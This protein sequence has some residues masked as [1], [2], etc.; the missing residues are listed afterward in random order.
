MVTSDGRQEQRSRDDGG[1]DLP[2]VRDEAESTRPAMTGI[3][4]EYPTGELLTERDKADVAWIEEA[5]AGS[6]A[7]INDSLRLFAGV[8]ATLFG[9]LVAFFDKAHLPGWSMA[10]RLPTLTLDAG[11]VA[12]RQSASDILDYSNPRNYSRATP[13]AVPAQAPLVQD[14]RRPLLRRPDDLLRGR[15]G[16]TVAERQGG[17]RQPR[18][19]Q[20]SGC[21]SASLSNSS[22]FQG[23]PVSRAAAAITD[24]GEYRAVKVYHYPAPPRGRRTAT[25]GRGR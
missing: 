17:R 25:G 9:L 23:C 8:S 18:R 16:R 1:S 7:A 10:A 21:Y 20:P 15:A 19:R 4:K 11:R 22:K 5:K 14:V 2:E 24:I 13:A 3:K 6:V 12:L